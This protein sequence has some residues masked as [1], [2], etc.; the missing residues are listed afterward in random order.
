MQ[1]KRIYLFN[2]DHD[3]ALASGKEHYMA[4]ASARQMA[5][6][7]ALL[8]AWYAEG[9]EACVCSSSV[10]DAAF[11]DAA[12]APFGVSVP[13]LSER[14]L[15]DVPEA[16]FLPWG[17][18]PALRRRLLTLGVDAARL[19]SPERLALFRKASHRSLAVSLLPMLRVDS[20]F[21]GESVYL[22]TLDA[23]RRFVESRKVSLLKAP[24]SGSGKGLN[25]CWD[26]FTPHIEGWCARLLT[27]QGGVVGEPIYN[28]VEDFAMEFY[29]DGRG[30]VAFVG[31]S[32][33]RTGRSGMYEGNTLL[34]D[35]A[36]RKRLST[37]VPVETLTL[38][39]ARWEELLARTLAPIAYQGYVGVDMM[40]CCFPE[41]EG[42]PRFRI[43]PCVEINLRM[44]MG[45]VAHRLYDRYVHPGSSGLFCVSYHATRGE[46]LR[47]HKRLFSAYPL[48]MGDGKICSG[49]MTL[50]PVSGKSCYRAWMVITTNICETSVAI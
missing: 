39:Q 3:L 45:V 44:N 9:E 20:H 37:Y 43:H 24:L 16:T 27:T 1:R 30:G 50:T 47:A 25:W 19:P 5:A 49:Y 40:I 33:F 8:P 46:A 14:E 29:A 42:E 26:L 38:L 12:Q 11:L 32:L 41:E 10:G 31:Y 17:W 6:D 34:S 35:V 15:A 21:C 36:I 48:K 4:P 28:K 23:C 13:L 7:L 18:N 22:S 2:P